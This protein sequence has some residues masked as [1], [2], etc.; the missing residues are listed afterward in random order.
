[1]RLHPS[2]ITHEPTTQMKP[3]QQSE[4]SAQVADSA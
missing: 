1:M 3:V 2:S 4:S